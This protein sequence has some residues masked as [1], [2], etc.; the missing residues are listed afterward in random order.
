MMKTLAVRCLVM[1]LLVFVGMPPGALAQDKGADLDKL[2][3]YYHEMGMFNGAVL[4]AEAGQIIYS[5]AFGFADFEKKI[6]LTSSSVFCIG[7]VTKPFT[8]LA[9]MILKEQGKL[10]Y[11]DKLIKFFPEFGT[12]AQDVTIRHL[13]T[14]TSGILDYA[15][16]LGMQLR[17]PVLTNTLVFDT[18]VRQSALKFQAGEKFAYSNSGYFLLAMVIEKV[19]GKK[20]REYLAD[21]IF[22]PLGMNDTYA[23]DETMAAIP[24]RVNAYVAPW[25]KNDEDLQF[26]VAGNGNIFSTIHDLWLF[27]R[28]LYGETLIRQSTLREAYDTTRLIANNKAGRKYGFGW[29]IMGQVASHRGGLG[30]FRCQYWRNIEKQDALIV[31]GNNTWLSSCPAILTGAQNIML[32]KPYSLAKQDVTALFFEQWYLK[33]FELALRRIQEAKA[34]ARERYDFPEQSINDLGYTFMNRMEFREAVEIFKLNVELYPE[35]ANAYDSLG[36]AYWKA[37]DT[38]QAI[39][40]YEKSLKLDPQNTGAVEILKKLRLR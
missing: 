1:S 4:A 29:H 7:S 40:N 37:G 10:A 36:E 38:E 34:G 35:S 39:F 16:D 13:L 32:G 14:H 11:D 15:N 5:R 2:F 21:T 19:S 18:L 24:N 23:Y 33:G 20:Y 17:H 9:I 28:A 27:D 31:L 25:Q 8:A 30:G 6:S 12:Y 26:K 22:R 3:S